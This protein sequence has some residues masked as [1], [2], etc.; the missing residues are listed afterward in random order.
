MVRLGGPDL[1]CLV[2]VSSPN[3]VCCR[4]S[5]IAIRLTPVGGDGGGPIMGGGVGHEY[6]GIVCRV[7]A[8]SLPITCTHAP[9][10]EPSG[11]LVPSTQGT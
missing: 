7:Q 10:P 4:F 1:A 3:N 11:G 5:V 2:R 8:Q 6:I 9:S